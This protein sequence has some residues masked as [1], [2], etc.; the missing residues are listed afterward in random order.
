MSHTFES[1]YEMIGGAEALA[2]L[3]DTFYNLVAKHPD[4]APIFPDDLTET[5][6]KQY[7]F[8]T[9]FFGGPAL[10]SQKHGHPMLRARHMPFPITPKRAEA[11]LS[12]MG[13]AMDGLELKDDV[14]K[15]VMDR[16]TLTAYHMINTRE[17]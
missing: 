12:C 6:E 17:E 5:K 14:R 8:L 9:Q 13:K 10:Y 16:L 7:M 3:V 2:R 1:Q 15:A 11:W 4:L